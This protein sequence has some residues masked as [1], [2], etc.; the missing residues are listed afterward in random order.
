MKMNAHI[1]V[2]Q[3]DDGT[4]KLGHSR[5]P[6]ERAKQ[7]GRPVVIVHQTD[8]I[9]HAERIERLAHR[10]L[11]LHGRHIRGEWFEATL[12]AAIAAIETAIRQAEGQE[13]ALGKSLSPLFGAEIIH[14]KVTPELIR[15]L[16][17]LRRAE[18]D[19]PSRSEMVRRLVERAEK[20]GLA[21]ENQRCG[22]ENTPSVAIHN[23]GAKV[24]ALRPRKR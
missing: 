18:P 13:L 22:H 8:V 2:M 14:M 7:I 6:T 12:D 24:F 17:N 4:L 1:Y 11:A 20:N 5:N 3:A 16:D 9:E 21:N 19:L 15:A 23:C 10:V